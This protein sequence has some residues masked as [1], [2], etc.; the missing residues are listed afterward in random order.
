ML[1]YLESP[2]SQNKIFY[3]KFGSPIFDVVAQETSIYVQ[4]LGSYT[5]SLHTY[6]FVLHVF[7][8]YIMKMNVWDYATDSWNKMEE[9][10]LSVCI[11]FLKSLF[12]LEP[13][14]QQTYSWIGNGLMSYL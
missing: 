9:G 8:G 14:R 11:S 7:L 2:V 12:G 10:A 3:S 4:V 5:I 6:I 1:S 13:R